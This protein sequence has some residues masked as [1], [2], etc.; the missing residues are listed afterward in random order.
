MAILLKGVITEI[1]FQDLGEPFAIVDTTVG[2]MQGDIGEDL[3]IGDTLHVWGNRKRSQYGETFFVTKVESINPVPEDV[4]ALWMAWRLPHIGAIRSRVVS[5]KLGDRLPEF[6]SNKDL[7]TK[8][9]SSLRGLTPKHIQEILA[10]YAEYPNELKL[11]LFLSHPDPERPL[12]GLKFKAFKA[13][14]VEWKGPEGLNE[15]I[16]EDM[17]ELM[18]RL[19]GVKFDALDNLGMGLGEDEQDPKRMRAL[20]WSHLKWAASN[21]HTVI[22]PEEMHAILGKNGGFRQSLSDSMRILTDGEPLSV[23]L[24]GV[25]LSNF[26]RAESTI[27][28]RAAGLLEDE[29]EQLEFDLSRLP[30]WLDESQRKAIIQLANEPFAVLTGG[31]GTGKTTVLTQLLAL[32]KQ[33]RAKIR[34]ASPTGKAAKRM[35]EVTKQNATTIHKLLE[36]KPAGFARNAK[37]PIDADVVIVDEASMLDTEIGAALFSALGRGTR[38]ILVGDVNQLPPVSAGQVLQDIMASE[39]V[40]VVKLTTTHRQGKDSWVIDAAPVILKG[41]VPSLKEQ[42]DFV[43][44]AQDS[45]KDIV[46]AVVRV[47]VEARASG[48]M[49]GLQVLTPEH[50][51]GAGVNMLNTVLQQRLNSNWVEGQTENMVLASK[52]RI[53][54]GD[55]VLYTKNDSE[56]T[57][58]N[59]SMGTVEAARTEKFKVASA[60]VRF[61]GEKN[62]QAKPGEDPELFTLEGEQV[63]P[64]VLAYAMTV[65]K[66]QGSEWPQIVVICE[67]SHYSMR[68][69]LLYTAITRTSKNLVI[70]G[71]V[72]SVKRAVAQNQDE[73]RKTL[74][75][76]R[77][78]GGV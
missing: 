26:A 63:A 59:G 32:L 23:S 16:Q 60:L 18:R 66:A 46:E 61:V 69:R 49:G 14:I 34:L 3:A 29:R 45:P 72:A 17:W 20:A 77:L 28:T 4:G 65:H 51:N 36:W 64:L 5:A 37:N 10:V 15:Q 9:L 75:Q 1:I 44:V 68:R 25:Q 41:G 43:F 55:K 67:K 53:F 50:N 48:T 35:S 52:V 74:L 40:P 22:A 11:A 33:T 57:L 58:V 13:A 70:I 27:A 78:R 8:S 12:H 71:D 30:D 2:K 39:V 73:S 21:G 62:P 42:S 47:Y 31:P 76:D 38:L 56:L 54:P 7:A 24:K 6:L 19:K